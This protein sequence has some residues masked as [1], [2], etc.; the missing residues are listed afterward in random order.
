MQREVVGEFQND[1]AGLPGIDNFAGIYGNRRRLTF[2]DRFVVEVGYFKIH[3]S[4]Q[5]FILTENERA[6][7]VIS[8]TDMDVDGFIT[9]E[10]VLVDLQFDGHLGEN[11]VDEACENG[12][13]YQFPEH[14][15]ISCF[16]YQHPIDSLSA[17]RCGRPAAIIFACAAAIS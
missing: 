12:G 6:S 2:E 8:Y 1:I 3:F 16:K 11:A 7:A 5:F 10:S 14:E 9:Y 17:R 4:E 15:K 13:Q